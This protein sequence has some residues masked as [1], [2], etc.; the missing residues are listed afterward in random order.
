MFFFL[1]LFLIMSWFKG[2]YL[3][4]TLLVSIMGL[5]ISIYGVAQ[6]SQKICCTGAAMANFGIFLREIRPYVLSFVNNRSCS[7]FCN[8]GK[9]AGQK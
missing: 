7:Y 9:P 4:I 5:G 1:K 2:I 6:E 8:N 3:V